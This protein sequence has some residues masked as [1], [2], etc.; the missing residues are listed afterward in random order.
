MSLKEQLQTLL[1]G[2]EIKDQKSLLQKL[3]GECLEWPNLDEAEAVEEVAYEWSKEDLNASGLEEKVVDGKV[4]QIQPLDTGQPFGIFLIEFKNKDAFTTGRGMVGPLRKVLRGL[5]KKKIGQKDQPAWKR[6]HL[7]FICTHKYQRYRI[8]YFKKPPEG[9]NLAQLASFSWGDGVPARTACEFN[10]PALQ[11]PQTDE[12]KKHWAQSWAK[13]FDVER[14]TRDFFREY[15][16]IFRGFEEKLKGSFDKGKAAEQKRLFTQQLFNRLMFLRFIERKEWLKF[17]DTTD[18]Y[19]QTLYAKRGS[20]GKSFYQARLKKLFF[21]ALAEKG[22]QEDPLIGKVPFLNGGLFEENDLDKR[23]DDIDDERFMRL[24][25][26]EGLFYKFNFTIEESTPLDIEVAVDPEMLGKVFEELVT[27]R[28]ESGSYYTPR[29]V[30][31]FM[32]RE[33]L[34]GY[35]TDKTGLDHDDVARL[36]DRRDPHG[37]KGKADAIREALARV[38]AVDPACGSGAY[39]LGLLHEIVELYDLLDNPDLGE[40]PDYNY[41]RKLHIITHNLYGVDKDR[42]ATNIAMLR[43][44][45]SLAVESRKPEA[46]PNLIYSVETGDALL[47]VDPSK[48][49]HEYDAKTKDVFAEGPKQLAIKIDELKEKFSVEHHAATKQKL[50]RQINAETAELRDTLGSK[51][52]EGVVEWGV[53]FAGVFAL[54][55]GFDIV[56]ANPPYVRQELIK[57]IKPKLKK[58]FGGQ[59]KGDPYAV[60]SGTADLFTYFYARALQLLRPGGMLVFISSNKWFRADYGKQLRNLFATRSRIIGVTDF[61][62]LPVFVSAIAYPMIFAASKEEATDQR[63]VFAAPPD[64]N[65]PYPDV[66]AVVEKYGAKL[67]K[68]AVTPERWLLTDKRTIEIMQQ[69]EKAGTPLGEYVNGEIYRGVLTGYNKAFYLNDEERARLI[70]KDPMSAEIIK[71]LARG[72]DIKRWLVKPSGWM[73]V[74]KIGVDMNRYPAVMDHLSKYEKELKKR[75]DQGNHWWELRACAYYDAFDGPKILYP[76]IAVSPQFALADAGVFTSN[77]TYM[78]PRGSRF[79]VGVLNSALMF[80][81]YVNVSSQIRGG[82]VRFFSHYVETLPI[83]KASSA[84]KSRVESLVGKCLEA[85]A[86]NADAGCSEWEH[87]INRIVATLYGLDPDEVLAQIA[88]QEAAGQA[89]A[90]DTEDADA[91]YEAYMKANFGQKDAD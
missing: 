33:A 75:Q 72:R 86:T 42:F 81:Y 6:E 87:E 13:A 65:D 32:C 83:P 59:Y 49:A 51:G 47:S 76:D 39:L 55:K 4:F 91:E 69:M 52:D 46:L 80:D 78:L 74:T 62:D 54:N 37:L 16:D 11:W 38:K 53:V 58:F 70:K 7:L 35:L 2:N 27:G 22:N 71:P 66:R 67:P 60:Y 56:L 19:L 17:E 50:L 68:G 77:T 63:P 9:S 84:T 44:W 3:L 23:V 61:R 12:Q 1:T 48:A 14:V 43:L 8:A 88:P 25:G 30:V 18:G 10:L 29:N 5:V 40:D 28:H 45:L 85:K 34:K 41:R 89:D 31:S 57:D 73:I 26:P 21:E 36:V 15:N 20:G 24:L 82:Y 64:L 90:A 79:L